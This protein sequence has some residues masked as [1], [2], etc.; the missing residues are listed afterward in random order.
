MSICSCIKWPVSCNKVSHH[1]MSISCCFD[2]EV[3]STVNVDCLRDFAFGGSVISSWCSADKPL[4]ESRCFFKLEAFFTIS[5]SH[6]LHFAR[7]TPLVQTSWK[8]CHTG[9][10]G[11]GMP[12]EIGLIRASSRRIRAREVVDL[13]IA[14]EKRVVNNRLIISC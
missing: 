2:C 9:F 11:V 5:T 1:L 6:A 3:V 8:L 10:F 4:Q 7:L 14:C 12:S 13:L